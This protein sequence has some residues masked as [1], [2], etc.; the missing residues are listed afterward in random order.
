MTPEQA[1]QILVQIAQ[2][3]PA[4]LSVH[5]QGMEAAK[6]L[7]AAITPADDPTPEP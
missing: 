5:Q 6:V 4:P 1:L 7:Q 3:A 2:Q